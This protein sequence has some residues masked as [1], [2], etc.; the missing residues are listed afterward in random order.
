MCICLCV[1]DIIYEKMQGIESLKIIGVKRS[2]INQQQ[3]AI[4]TCVIVYMHFVGE[5]KT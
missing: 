1:K 2:K 3:A 4:D 5:L